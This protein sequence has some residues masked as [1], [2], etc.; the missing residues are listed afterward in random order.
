MTAVQ[1]KYRVPPLDVDSADIKAALAKFG[2]SSFRA[3]QEETISRILAG[4]SSLALLATGTGKSLI[5]QLPAYMYRERSACIT[6]V[7]SP[8]V[9][10]MEDQVS[11]HPALNHKINGQTTELSKELRVPGGGLLVE[12]LDL[13]ILN[14]CYCRITLSW[15]AE[16][17]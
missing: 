16:Q 17:N 10:L 4:K 5:Y 9:S 6:L 1:E 12:E 3:G 2:Y 15:A 7:V 13:H 8:L 11:D 14:I